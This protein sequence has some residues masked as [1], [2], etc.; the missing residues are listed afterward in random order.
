VEAQQFWNKISNQ[1]KQ[2]I[3]ANVWCTRCCVGVAMIGIA[4]TV[5]DESLVLRGHCA[6]CGHLVARVLEGQE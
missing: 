3:L 6:S 4:G 5:E 1:T 2:K